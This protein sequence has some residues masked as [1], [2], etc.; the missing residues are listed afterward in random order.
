MLMC[1]ATP[2]ILALNIQCLAPTQQPL[3]SF[4]AMIQIVHNVVNASA[5]TV[6][7]VGRRTLM[8]VSASASTVHGVG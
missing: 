3:P 1:V 5:L 7:Q 8:L 6:I 4:N 2:R